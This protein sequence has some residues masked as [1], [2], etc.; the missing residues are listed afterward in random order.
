MAMT[1]NLNDKTNLKK[2]E[3]QLEDSTDTEV[4]IVSKSSFSWNIVETIF[5]KFYGK[6]RFVIE[7]TGLHHLYNFLILRGRNPFKLVILYDFYNNEYLNGERSCY[8][9]L[10]TI[11]ILVGKQQFTVRFILTEMNKK[12]L[13][14]NRGLMK[15]LKENGIEIEYG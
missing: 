4:V 7:T 10:Q 2:I 1:I 15:D 8:K 12:F 5:K 9:T 13:E 14:F 6:F 3:K 11:L